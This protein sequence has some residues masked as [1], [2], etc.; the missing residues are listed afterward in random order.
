MT[1]HT[2]INVSHLHGFTFYMY[3]ST[4][5]ICVFIVLHTSKI[6]LVMSQGTP[7]QVKCDTGW[8]GN[9]CQFQCHCSG[10]PDCTFD[11]FCQSGCDPNWFGPAC[12]YSSLPFT[13][14][15]KSHQGETWLTDKNDR[16]CNSLG[17]EVVT[18]A[19]EYPH[20]LT[21][22]RVVMKTADQLEK[23]ALEYRSEK[24]KARRI[25]CPHAESALIDEKTLDIYCLTA[26]PIT[27]LTLI[28]AAVKNLCNLHISG[29]RNVALR[30]PTKHSSEY[31]GWSSQ[32]AVDGKDDNVAEPED[33]CFQT[34]PR[35][36][37]EDFGWWS[38]DF[39]THVD[40]VRGEITN[41]KAT[42]CEKTPLGY[43]FWV[44]ARVIPYSP[45]PFVYINNEPAPARMFREVPNP[46]IAWPGRKVTV[47]AV[48]Q[49]VN[50]SFSF[51]E[52]AV[53]GE[54]H[55]APGTFG[56]QC[57][58]TCNCKGQEACFVSTGACPSGCALG[59]TGE[60]CWTPCEDGKYGSGCRENCSE[61]CHF[62]YSCNKTDGACGTG[63]KPGYKKPLCK[64]SCDAGTYGPDC[65]RSCSE[66]CAGSQKACHNVDG[67][68]LHGC[69]PGFQAPLCQE[70]IS[71]SGLQVWKIIL[72]VVLAIIVIVVTAV[73]VWRRRRGRRS[74]PIDDTVT[75]G[76][77]VTG[78]GVKMES[79]PSTKKIFSNY[80]VLPT[81]D[82]EED[83][84]HVYATDF[85]HY[86]KVVEKI[87]D[88][89]RPNPVACKGAK[90]TSKAEVP[91]EQDQD[92]GQYIQMMDVN[93][94]EITSDKAN[95][96][97]TCV[98]SSSTNI[99]KLD[100]GD[101]EYLTPLDDDPESVKESGYKNV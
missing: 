7:I 78:Q 33:T 49:P 88:N 23:L 93:S 87:N 72:I 67:F 52:V 59:N 8:F 92:S 101:G 20:P 64:E 30:Q 9:R 85:D 97:Y 91:V 53:F 3:V 58:H 55:C 46:R 32:N 41:P 50:V 34:V 90:D 43:R 69:E 13:T 99:T 68:C 61:N 44:Y 75:A 48:Q 73:V 81:S 6:N 37:N 27:H 21:W 65:V 74:T 39:L 66:N 96:Y 11:G 62:P 24:N 25:E 63:C 80:D 89:S 17:S 38:V 86:D 71:S 12:Q 56:R 31:E 40:I 94:P 35:A 51:C 19:L 10:P 70:A 18:V 79:H 84:I 95:P 57:E 15:G 29:G 54:S 1:C 60:N 16:T 100:A 76:N 45:E 98:K 83:A 26:E 47:Q 4:F 42:C 28:G 14:Y 2:R 5:K 82:P 77:E 36:E 22:I